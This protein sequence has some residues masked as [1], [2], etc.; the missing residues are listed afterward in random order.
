[1]KK[2]V[3]VLLLALLVVACASTQTYTILYK[4]D[5]TIQYDAPTTLP[6]L[7]PGES[8]V[9]RVW[10]WDMAQGAPGATTTAGWTFYAETAVLEQYVITPTDPRREYAVGIQTVHLKADDTEAAGYFAMTTNPADVDPGGVPGVPFTY[11]P[12]S[13]QPPAKVRNL[14]DS[15]M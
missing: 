3:L 5:F 4:D 11:A 1:M 2:L 14:R 12:G 10:L 8:L 6:E 7:L 15:G 9:Y 13:L